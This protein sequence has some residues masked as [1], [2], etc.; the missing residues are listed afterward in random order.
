MALVAL[1]H[2]HGPDLCFKELLLLTGRDRGGTEPL[3]L[4]QCT[5]ESGETQQKAGRK[6]G[7]GLH[8]WKGRDAL[9]KPA[10]VVGSPRPSGEPLILRVFPDPHAMKASKAPASVTFPNKSSQQ[11]PMGR[12]S[13]TPRVTGSSAQMKKRHTDALRALLLTFRPEMCG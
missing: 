13:W 3:K 5:Q 8:V 7:L 12:F 11:F 10:V 4:S 2:Q 1:A 9:G 6:A